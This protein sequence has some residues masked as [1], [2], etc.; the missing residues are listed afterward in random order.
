MLRTIQAYEAQ[1]IDDPAALFPPCCPA[2]QETKTFR[3]HELRP[4][5]FWCCISNEVKHVQSVVLRV[6][7]K[8]CGCR[9]TVLPEFALPHK[10]YVLPDLV[11]ASQRF[12]LDDAATHESSTKIDGQPVF[13]DTT[14]VSRAP[15]T[16]HRWIGFL[17]SLV[18][19]LGNATELAMEANPAFSPLAEMLH[20]STRRYRTD[21]RREVLER[22]HRL[23]RVRSS[24]LQTIKREIFPTI[25][26]AE[27]WQ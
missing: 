24:L 8:L 6:A 19:L 17:G 13:H 21:D 16:V 27:V 5:G 11:D 9:T 18:T 3:K 12:L 4:R 10:R 14:G 26:T 2:C 1:L 20:F 22:A 23:L 15:S 7:C 25:A